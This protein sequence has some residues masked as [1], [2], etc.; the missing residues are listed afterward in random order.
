MK[1]VM[2]S[3]CHRQYDASSMPQDSLLRCLCGQAVAV[4]ALAP[5]EPRAL[6]CS[7]CGAPF[8]NDDRTCGHCQAE[9]TIE[10]RMLSAVC[11]GCGARMSEQAKHCMECG[12]AIALQKI[13]PLRWDAKCPRCD[14]ELRHRCVD[15]RLDLIEC[16]SCAGIWLEPDSFRGV[17]RE[18]KRKHFVGEGRHDESKPDLERHAMRYLACPVCSERMM[19]RGF[20]KGSGIMLDVCREHGVWFDHR[21]LE[22]VTRWIETHGESTDVIRKKD[23]NYGRESASPTPSPAPSSRPNS[24]SSPWDVVDVFTEIIGDLFNIG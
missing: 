4:E 22:A 2:C 10:E 18:A 14:S 24:K 7:S 5:H 11:P 21:E 16:S 3:A 19:P 8:Q 6:R 12:L 13:A 15:D 23:L 20:G 1:I 9:T 17:V